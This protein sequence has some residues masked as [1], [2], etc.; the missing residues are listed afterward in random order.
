V[1][2]PGTTRLPLIAISVA[3]VLWSTSF[4][5]IEEALKTA[6]PS[7]VSVGRFAIAL[8]VLVPLAARRKGFAAALRQPR[9]VLLALLGV[10]LHYSLTTVGVSFTTAGAAALAGASLPVLTAVLALVIL[11]ERLAVRTSIGLVLATAGIAIVAGSGLSLDVG[12]VLCV[13]A[14]VCYALYTV[15]LR[16]GGPVLAKS[17]A[18]V[19][20]DPLV[21]A[22]STALWG[23]V[24]MLP[25]IAFDALVGTA[26]L[27]STWSGIGSVVFLGLVVT[28]PTVVL[29]I[30]GAERLPAAISG[31]STAAV[32]ALGYVFALLLGEPLNVRTA[33][34]GAI[35]LL[36]VFVA[37]W[38]NRRS[39]TA[40]QEPTTP[41]SVARDP[42]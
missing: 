24:L 3:V 11:R 25:W 10:A 1:A 5:A 16:R 26:S 33:L 7:V 21:L 35:A 27:P 36:G 17:R 31:V 14:H 13:L 9:I 41:D 39:A 42:G 23:T 4:V 30:Y 19:D 8:V 28:A 12:V 34:G 18:S 38:P 22:A 29:F 2:R 15:L 20:I 40:P 37:T 6:S 32:P